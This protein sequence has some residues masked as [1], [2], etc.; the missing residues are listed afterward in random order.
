MDDQAP[1]TAEERRLNFQ[2]EQLDYEVILTTHESSSVQALDI[3]VYR[4]DETHS[5]SCWFKY[6]RDDWHGFPWI[7]SDATLSCQQAFDLLTDLS[8]ETH[9]GTEKLIT[10]IFPVMPHGDEICINISVNYP[11]LTANVCIGL[12]RSRITAR[13][14]SERMCKSLERRIEMLERQLELPKPMHA[15]RMTEVLANFE[16]RLEKLEQRNVAAPPTS[17]ARC[18]R[19]VDAKLSM[20]PQIGTRKGLWYD[21]QLRGLPDETCFQLHSHSSTKNACVVIW[22][23][24]FYF[25]H[26]QVGV[27]AQGSATL[28]LKVNGKVQAMTYVYCYLKDRVTS[29]ILS[30]TLRLQSKDSLD[31]HL[32]SLENCSSHAGAECANQFCITKLY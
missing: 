18:I 16:A 21:W 14:L 23:D 17:G 25:C 9:S 15:E 4:L 3:R 8:S 2:R 5:H 22:Q 26:A 13:E 7:N 20:G 30:T 32:E 29:C 10:A 24:G 11:Y 1:K 27:L 31:L 6:F 12:Q 19:F 28:S